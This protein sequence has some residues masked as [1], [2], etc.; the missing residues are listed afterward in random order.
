MTSVPVDP[1]MKR[2]PAASKAP[3]AVGDLARLTV[4]GLGNKMRNGCDDA[5]L[6]HCTMQGLRK[7][8]ATGDEPMAIFG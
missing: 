4:N 3:S 2:S 7:A 8:G 6:P 1:G 5:E